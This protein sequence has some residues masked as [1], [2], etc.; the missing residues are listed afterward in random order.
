MP[1]KTA[2]YEWLTFLGEGLYETLNPYWGYCEGG[3]VLPERIVILH[4]PKMNHEKHRAVDGFSIL[5]E[6]YFRKGCAK[7]EGVSFDPEDIS[8]FAK[9][10]E[11]V[12]R[13]AS[14]KS[15]MLIVDISPATWSFVP[16]H[17]TKIAGAHHEIVKS[18][19]YLHYVDHAYRNRPYPLIPR[20][21]ITFHDLFTD[22]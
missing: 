7:I 6:E 20:L 1:S 8:D 14:A 10:A 22:F 15:R 19:I 5:S 12:F 4:P 21:G 18:I 9:R 3:G 11:A 17:L 2:A 16:S 13:D